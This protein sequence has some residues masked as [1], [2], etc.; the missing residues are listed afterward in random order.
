V[1]GS[2]LGLGLGLS[3]GYYVTETEVFQ[4]VNRCC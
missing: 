3:S 2:G 1:L 4:I